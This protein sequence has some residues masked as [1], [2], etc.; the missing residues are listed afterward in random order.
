MGLTSFAG[1]RVRK[2]DIETA[3]N[4]LTQD[5]LTAMNRLVTMY[6]DFAEDQA[7]H[8][9]PMHMADWEEKLNGFLQFTGREVLQG[10]G[11]ISHNAAIEKVEAEYEKFDLYRRSAESSEALEELKSDIKKIRG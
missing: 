9:I 10:A 6:L 4:Y 11:R 8:R 1:T 7:R 2:K 5:E 3:K